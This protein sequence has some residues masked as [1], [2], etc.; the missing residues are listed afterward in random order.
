M[1]PFLLTFKLYSWNLAFKSIER[2]AVPRGLPTS[3]P[4]FSEPISGGIYCYPFLVN[5]LRDVSCLEKHYA[6][7]HLCILPANP[8]PPHLHRELNAVYTVLGRDETVHRKKNCKQLYY[9]K[10][11]VENK[12]YLG[13]FVCVFFFLRFP[14]VAVSIGFVVNKK[15]CC[16]NLWLVKC[17]ALIFWERVNESP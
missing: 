9:E 3:D 14:F 10:K 1:I 13:K 8:P 2:H 5:P 15:V 6:C 11:F 17:L 12:F 4:S 7:M 16:L